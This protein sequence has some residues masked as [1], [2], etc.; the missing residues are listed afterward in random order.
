MLSALGS[1]GIWKRPKKISK[2]ASKQHVCCRWPA[3]KR[4]ALC[5]WLCFVIGPVRPAALPD[6]GLL[7]V[8]CWVSWA[9]RCEW[10][11]MFGIGTPHFWGKRGTC[12]VENLASLSEEISPFLKICATYLE[13]K[14]L[15]KYWTTL[16]ASHYLLLMQL[17]MAGNSLGQV[18]QFISRKSYQWE[19]KNPLCLFI[20]LW[21]EKDWSLKKLF[22][23]IPTR[24]FQLLLLKELTSSQ[25]VCERVKADSSSE[26]GKHEAFLGWGVHHFQRCRR[27]RY[28]STKALLG[29][30][31]LPSDPLAKA[32]ESSPRWVAQWRSG[33]AV[34]EQRFLTGNARAERSSCLEKGRA[35]ACEHGHPSWLQFVPKSSLS[36][37]E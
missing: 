36:Q 14:R 26:A 32:G 24:L 28:L 13:M 30:L 22:F 18:V 34:E 27:I 2:Q 5:R 16:L 8:L 10:C 21:T 7:I 23:Y 17:V 15:C 25:P 31:Q 9:G 6:T 11:W 29:F 35:Q 19:R 20:T 12:S 37:L 4:A 1:C 33:F 3:V